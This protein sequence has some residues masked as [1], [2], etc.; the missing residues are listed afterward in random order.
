M[1]KKKKWSSWKHPTNGFN[2]KLARR[3]KW[4]CPLIYI[5]ES[6]AMACKDEEG[7]ERGLFSQLS[8]EKK[9][10]EVSETWGKW[11]GR[12]KW[13]RSGPHRVQS[14][15]WLNHHLVG[16]R[17][18]RQRRLKCSLKNL[19]SKKYKFDIFFRF[20]KLSPYLGVKG[21][22][23]PFSQ[24][25]WFMGFKF[26]QRKYKSYWDQIKKSKISKSIFFEIK[27]QIPPLTCVTRVTPGL[28]NQTK[29]A[30][31]FPKLFKI[32]I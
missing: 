20:Q 10:Q 31:N 26:K 5:W 25:T 17:W 30:P 18:N 19:V 9:L 32:L 2:E 22:F 21:P 6:L 29:R 4:R 3:G 13:V 7:G 16:P 8:L 1:R 28:S 23:C 27:S 12:L 14:L 11:G 24:K 15:E